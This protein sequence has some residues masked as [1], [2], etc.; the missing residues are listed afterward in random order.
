MTPVETAAHV[1]REFRETETDYNQRAFGM[2]MAEWG[3][4]VQRR[5]EDGSTRFRRSHLNTLIER[6]YLS[7][8]SRWHQ[9]F[10]AAMVGDEWPTHGDSVAVSLASEGE[11][12]ADATQ[13]IAVPV[14]IGGRRGRIRFVLELV[15]VPAFFL[16]LAYGLLNSTGYLPWHFPNDRQVTAK[17]Q[18]LGTGGGPLSR[19]IV[20]I[21]PEYAVP[22]QQVSIKAWVQPKFAWRS[23]FRLADKNMPREEAILGWSELQSTEY[24]WDTSGYQPGNYFISIEFVYPLSRIRPSTIHQQKY[25][26]VDEDVGQEQ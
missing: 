6:C 21:E 5:L 7:R 20:Q 15:F 18:L 13:R 14:R 22:G 24:V 2:L 9:R 17:A 23:V 3:E 8:G 19:H 10:E 12:E 26:L 16:A 1:L 11:Q 25:V 4:N